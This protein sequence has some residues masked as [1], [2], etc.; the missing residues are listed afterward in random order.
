MHCPK[1]SEHTF[2]A[3]RPIFSER[4]AQIQ[5]AVVAPIAQQILTEPRGATSPIAKLHRE[6]PFR[7]PRYTDV[8]QD[9]KILMD[10]LLS[11]ISH[12]AT[13]DMFPNKNSRYA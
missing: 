12:L 11:V 9:S 3:G 4:V 10:P 6:A 2:Y 13:I 5:A 8:G 1:D 7:V